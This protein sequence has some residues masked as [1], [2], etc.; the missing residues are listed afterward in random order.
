MTNTYYNKKYASVDD[1]TWT[2]K[3]LMDKLGA[4]GVDTKAI[5]YNIKSAI[6]STLL[7]RPV[8]PSQPPPPVKPPHSIGSCRGCLLGWAVRGGLLPP[9]VAPVVDVSVLDACSTFCAD[10][11]PRAPTHTPSAWVAGWWALGVLLGHPGQQAR[12]RNQ[13]RGGG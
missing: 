9:T 11:S 13:G 1:L 12:T 10:T 5:M 2:F 3:Q 7:V 4:S 8:T 6:V